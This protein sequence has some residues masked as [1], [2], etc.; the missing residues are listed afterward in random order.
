MLSNSKNNEF[1]SSMNDTILKDIFDHDENEIYT[2][3]PNIHERT[4]NSLAH[5]W[6]IC[7]IFEINESEGETQYAND[8]ENETDLQTKVTKQNIVTH[9]D[10]MLNETNSHWQNNKVFTQLNPC[11]LKDNILECFQV[12]NNFN[13]YRIIK[14]LTSDLYDYYVSQN[15]P[16]KNMRTVLKKQFPQKS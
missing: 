10:N 7:D 14:F 2:S 16:H 15:R 9:S 11:K 6:S 8:E 13:I 12:I 5:E 4:L 1:I 3:S